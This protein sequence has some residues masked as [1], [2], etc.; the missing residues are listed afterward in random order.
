MA[1]DQSTQDR[2]VQKARA[3]EA[4]KLEGGVPSLRGTLIKIAVLG[5]VDAGVI[6]SSL[7]LIAKHQWLYLSVA[8]VVA[9]VINWIYLRKGH[10]PAKY[11][12]PGVLLLIAFQISIVI[13]SGIIAFTNYGACL[14]YTSP[15]PRDG[16][17]SR[18]PSSA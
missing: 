14:L 11:L 13:F 7:L 5:I 16:L 3:R 17:L 10:L 2:A 1:K 15:S 8:L 18:M 4:R 12:A 6:F 9:F